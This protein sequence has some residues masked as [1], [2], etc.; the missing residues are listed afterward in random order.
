MPLSEAWREATG[1]ELPATIADGDGSAPD[2]GAHGTDGFFV[3][4]LRRAP[5]AKEAE[6]APHESAA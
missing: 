1:G 4:V 3:C 6:A 5:K 2:P